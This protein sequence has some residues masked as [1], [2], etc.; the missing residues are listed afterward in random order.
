MTTGIKHLVTCRCVL[1]Q[2]KRAD[3]PPRHQFVVFSIIDGDV[4]RP[5]FAQC[6]N[7]GIIHR[8]TDVCRS[9]IKQGREDMRSIVT[10]DDVRPSLPPRLAETLDA[11]DADLPTWEAA[12]HL[13][14]EK[15][16][17]GFVVLSTDVDGNTRHGKY[18]Q[19]LGDN[20]FKV[21]SFEREE[22]VNR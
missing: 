8:V 14:E 12:K 3:N 21:D 16:W 13:V 10:I 4:V 22:E 9:E 1:P 7:C 18:V 17:G 15:Q 2:F 5:K 20:M 19:V 6:N 11:A